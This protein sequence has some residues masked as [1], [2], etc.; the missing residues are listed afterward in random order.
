MKQE[1]LLFLIMMWGGDSIRRIGHMVSEMHARAL[2]S[3]PVKAM[4]VMTYRRL[5]LAPG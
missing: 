2:I 3:V 4:R 5:D 1:A